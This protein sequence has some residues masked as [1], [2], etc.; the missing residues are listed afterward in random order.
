MPFGPLDRPSLALGLLKAILRRDG[1]NSTVMYPNLYFAAD[2]GLEAYAYLAGGNPTTDSLFGEWLFAPW[3]FDDEP[4][5]TELSTADSAYIS[6]V[7]SRA[8]TGWIRPGQLARDLRTLAQG[9]RGRVP[10]FLEHWLNAPQWEFAKLVGFTSNTHQHVASLAFARRLKKRYPHLVVLFGGANLQKPMGQATLDCFGYID[11]VVQGE[12]DEVVTPLV[13]SILEG[14]PDKTISPTSERPR[15][16][17]EPPRP[18]VLDELPVPDYEEYFETIRRLPALA[19]VRPVVPFETSRGCWWGQRHQCLFC[20]LCG[21]DISYRSKSPERAVSEISLL[22]STH[23]HEAI[24]MSA[25]DNVLD[26]RYLRTVLPGLRS[27]GIERRI[28]YEVRVTLAKSE[29]RD[30]AAAGIKIVGLGIESL[31]TKLLKSMGKGTTMIQNLQA[32]KWCFEAG[33]DPEWNFLWGFPGE[34]DEDYRECIDLIS[35]LFHLPP[36]LCMA[37]IH[38]DRYSPLFRQAEKEHSGHPPPVEAYSEIYACLPPDR[39][40]ELAYHFRYDH[41]TPSSIPDLEAAIGTWKRLH[42]TAG[43]FYFDDAESDCAILVDTRRERRVWTMDRNLARVLDRLDSVKDIDHLADEFGLS[44]ADCLERLKTLTGRRVLMSEGSQ[45]LSLASRLGTYQPS[46]GAF[47][48]L[49]PLVRE[50]RGTL[51]SSG[52]LTWG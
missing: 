27:T 51:L 16:L 26:A 29:F 47:G 43:L 50:D 20:G 41:R 39:R 5:Y 48:A 14:A 44:Q 21:S 8:F 18:T 3:L 9:V 15:V 42:G 12:A 11:G 36:P 13:R 49:R 19:D 32:L 31:S 10:G 30:L 46:P 45:Y 52:H 40:S 28:F 25:S 37:R 17:V 38:M 1:I 22:W 7:E 35:A 2:V 4:D 6:S 24:G 23:Q 34:T 33:V